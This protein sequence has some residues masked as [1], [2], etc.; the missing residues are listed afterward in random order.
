MDY[1]ANVPIFNQTD[2]LTVFLQVIFRSGIL[3]SHVRG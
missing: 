3:K 2:N 1:L